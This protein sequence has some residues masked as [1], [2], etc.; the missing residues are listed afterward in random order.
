MTTLNERV[1]CFI[2]VLISVLYIFTIIPFSVLHAQTRPTPSLSS[3]QTSEPV[4]TT[5]RAGEPAPFA[6]TL[7]SVSAAA[8]MLANLELTQERCDLQINTRVRLVE[9]NM[10]LT[11]DIER[12]K[13]T[14]L[15]YRLSETTRIKNDQINFLLRQHRPRPWYESGEFWF[16]LGSVVGVI[17]TVAAGYA[18]GQAYN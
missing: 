2:S 5:V 4:M 15:E 9:A 3:T 6:G 16:G 13:I 1:L 11:I 17:I 7:F 14:A 12:A 10:Q 18:L 8:Q